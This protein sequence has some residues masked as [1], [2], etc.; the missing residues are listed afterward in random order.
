MPKQGWPRWLGVLASV[1]VVVAG[2]VFVLAMGA[3][4]VDALTARQGPGEVPKFIGVLVLFPAV[5]VGACLLG[6]V[7]GAAVAPF[8]LERGDPIRGRA[9]G[10]S[11]AIDVSV[12]A[13]VAWALKDVW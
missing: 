1:G 11:A 7:V 6:A 2:L 8:R 10:A 3:L 5:A 12:L 4:V 13:F 9:F